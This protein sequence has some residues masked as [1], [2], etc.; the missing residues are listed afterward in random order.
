M[1]E[2]FRYDQARSSLNVRAVVEYGLEYLIKKFFI[3]S[4]LAD[5]WTLLSKSAL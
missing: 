4:L 2:E 3:Y 1:Y 5:N